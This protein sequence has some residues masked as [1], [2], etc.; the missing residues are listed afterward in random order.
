[1]SWGGHPMI[2]PEKTLVTHGCGLSGKKKTSWGNQPL[3]S[4]PQI[5]PAFRL[6]SQ[7]NTLAL[8]NKQGGDQGT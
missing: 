6:Q 1:M 2:P 7:D 5:T 4:P 8:S 3:G